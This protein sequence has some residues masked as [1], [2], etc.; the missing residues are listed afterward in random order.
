MR[1]LT[2]AVL[3]LAAAGCDGGGSAQSPT[4][5]AKAVLPGERPAAPAPPGAVGL[6]VIRNPEHGPYLTDLNGRPLY[7]LESDQATS[8][9]C[10]DT[11]V[12]VWPPLFAGQ[13]APVTGDSVVDARLVATITRRDG[14][15]LV[16]FNGHPLYYNLDDGGPGADPRTSRGRFMGRV[17]PGEPSGRASRGPRAT[18]ARRQSGR[19]SARARMNSRNT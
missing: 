16:S 12:G 5:Q 14:L 9:G 15:R 19:G 6:S 7:L 10:H 11:G 18:P 2:S 13:T 1:R 17:V 3:V 4:A 8:G